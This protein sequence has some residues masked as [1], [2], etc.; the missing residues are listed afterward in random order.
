MP[1]LKPPPPDPLR[2]T[3]R[4]SS[5]ILSA[6]PSSY[7]ICASAREAAYSHRLAQRLGRLDIHMVPLCHLADL[8][9]ATPRPI[10][11]DHYVWEVMNAGDAVTLHTVRAL[12]AQALATEKAS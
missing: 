12:A 6:P 7:Y 1:K 3:G 9:Q 2:R 10:V 11:V 4:T 5:A 8:A